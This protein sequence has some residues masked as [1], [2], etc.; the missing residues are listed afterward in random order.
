MPPP[1]T[2]S[3]FQNSE[4]TPFFDLKKH[5][6]IAKVDFQLF[7]SQLNKADFLITYIM[8]TWWAIGL[9][10]II[11]LIFGGVANGAM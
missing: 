5:G 2:G 1:R 9:L 7:D 6:S 3:G 11:S 8:L 4:S 10:S